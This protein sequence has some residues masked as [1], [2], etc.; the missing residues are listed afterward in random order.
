ML[1]S[2][3]VKQ[4]KSNVLGAGFKLGVPSA[5]DQCSKFEKS[6]FFFQLVWK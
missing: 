2:T 1:D 3:V 4:F 5:F 6:F